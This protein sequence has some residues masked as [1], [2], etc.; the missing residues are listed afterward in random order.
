MH[1]FKHRKIKLKIII[2]NN[3]KSKWIAIVFFKKKNHT[4]HGKWVH[5]NSLISIWCGAFQSKILNPWEFLS[6]IFAWHNCQHNAK[7]LVLTQDSVQ[8][9]H[10]LGNGKKYKDGY[11]VVLLSR[12]RIEKANRDKEPLNKSSHARDPKQ[13]SSGP[14]E[15]GMDKTC[16]FLSMSR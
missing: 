3:Y 14:W 6:L 7:D 1:W 4:W 12:R 11:E 5:L 15:R 13:W 16:S 8:V 10:K 9:K 2:N